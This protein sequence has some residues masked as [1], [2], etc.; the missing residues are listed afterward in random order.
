LL[1]GKISK[2]ILSQRVN[3]NSKSEKSPKNLKASSS[4]SL[5]LAQSNYDKKY[6]KKGI[7]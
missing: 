1:A 7:G 6:A 5:G 3:Y 4:S 2:I